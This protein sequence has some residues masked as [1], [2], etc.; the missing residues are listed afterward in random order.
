[1]TT[2]PLE[3]H[4]RVFDLFV[5]IVQK[6]A[7][8][9][10]I[11]RDF[12]ALTV[13]VDR[14]EFFDEGDER[15]VHVLRRLG[16]ALVWFVIGLAAHVPLDARSLAFVARCSSAAATSGPAHG[17]R[18]NDVANAR[19]GEFHARRA[20]VSLA[21]GLSILALA[22]VL[23]GVAAAWRDQGQRVTP[24]LATFATVAA[25]GVA[26]LHLLPEAIVEGGAFTLIPLLVAL[27]VPVL[28]ERRTHGSEASATGTLIAGYI[29][30][31]L[32]QA[33]EGTAIATL[34][35]T[36]NLNTT[37]ILAVAAHT[38]PLAMIVAIRARSMVTDAHR[39][40]VQASL[41]LVGCAL[42][43]VVGALSLEVINPAS[44]AQGKPWLVAAVAGLL[45]HALFHETKRPDEDDLRSR[46]TDVA[47]SLVGLAVS[48]VS[49]EPD[50]WIRLISWPLRLA[51]LGALII[52]VVAR[53]FVRTNHAEAR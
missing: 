37:I 40:I 46:V 34:A 23:G 48:V 7:T 30:V 53:V 32:H 6:H 5:T 24:G 8:Q 18:R 21:V 15:A 17:C 4:H 36:N 26:L 2:D 38:I 35:R 25:A 50:G 42:A 45:L 20:L 19:R 31:L 11:S 44:I 28:I 3:V 1:M 52:A 14:F 9:L 16:Q 33:G 12:G 29:A 13:P 49:L 41:A 51:L 22:V 47:A 10:G 27:F 39:G 43:T